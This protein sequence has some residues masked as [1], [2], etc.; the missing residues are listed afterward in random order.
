MSD[1]ILELRTLTVEQFAEALKQVC[2][3][4]EVRIQRKGNTAYLIGVRLSQTTP[5]H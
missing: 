1:I 4:A 2:A 5:R 3:A